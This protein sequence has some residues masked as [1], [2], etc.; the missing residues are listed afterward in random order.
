MTETGNILSHNRR[1]NCYF[2]LALAVNSPSY[3]AQWQLL[4]DFLDDYGTIS[5][6]FHKDIIEKN[7][8]RSLY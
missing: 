4:Q 6:A 8:L 7:I 5:E 1:I 2:I 3:E